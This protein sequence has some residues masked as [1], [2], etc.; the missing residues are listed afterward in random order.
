MYNCSEDSSKPRREPLEV[1][2]YV[3]LA[4]LLSVVLA[5]LGDL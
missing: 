3:C 1:R 4:L 5:V 2:A